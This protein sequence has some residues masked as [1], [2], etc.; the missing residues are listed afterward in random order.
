MDFHKYAADETS[1][2]IDR[3]VS[4]SSDS[5]TQQLL[6]FKLAV[7]SA[8]ETLESAITTRPETERD[9]SA[10]V[11]R[12]VEASTTVTTENVQRVIDEARGVAEALRGEIDEQREKIAGLEESLRKAQERADA[13][14]ADLNVERGRIDSVRAEMNEIIESHVKELAE[15]RESHTKLES[16]WHEAVEARDEELRARRT[17]E[18]ELKEVRDSL[19]ASRAEIARFGHELEAAVVERSKLEDAASLAHS[20][21]QAADAKLEAVTGLFKTSAARVKALERAQKEY[22]RKGGAGPAK[23]SGTA[24]TETGAASI[25]VLEELLG[26]FDALASATTIGD[27]L[28][29]LTEHVAAEF[30]RVALFRVKSNRLEG[31]HQIGVDSPDIKTILIPFEA[32]SMLTRA[33]ISSRVERRTG[34]ALADSELPFEGTPTCAVALPIIVQ[35]ETVAVVYADDVGQAARDAAALHLS[36]RFAE[37]LSQHATA[38]LARLT[39]EL[40]TLAELRTYAGSLLTEIE[41]MYLSDVSAGKDGVELQKRL[42][43]NV[44]YARS[45]Y[46]NRAALEGAAAASLLEDQLTTLI[47]MKDGTSFGRDLAAVARQTDRQESE[48]RS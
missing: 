14:E 30:P 11:E 36:S 10:L 16:T 26:S 17:I 34:K 7:T 13:L 1:A 6:K 42:K 44:E 21:A 5:S 43:A 24:S 40:K 39:T 31:E 3:L 27:V 15:A 18:N 4:G 45:I 46:A 48:S 32:D 2:L 38:L 29:T 47:E 8:L 20:Q 25:S 19:E 12:L 35:G 41:E 9:V 23:A 28:T 37:A 33:A 22:E